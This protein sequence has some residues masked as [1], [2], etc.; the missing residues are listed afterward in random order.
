M[1]PETK[2]ALAVLITFVYVTVLL[3]AFF[4]TVQGWHG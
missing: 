1:K 4:L 3:G 2:L